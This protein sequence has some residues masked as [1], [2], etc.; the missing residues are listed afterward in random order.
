WREVLYRFLAELTP[1][2]IEAIAAFAYMEMLERG[3]T[4]VGEFHYLHHDVDGRPYADIGEMAARIA[5]AAAR[6]GIGLTLLPSFYANGGFGG[7]APTYAQRRFLNGPDDFLELLARTREIAAGVPDAEV[8]VAPH[9]LR[10]VTP[11][12]LRRVITACDA[13]PIHI[14]AAEQKK[15]VKESV[16]AL[17]RPPVAW[18]VDNCEIGPRWC[19]VHATHMDHAETSR[20]ARSGAVAGLCPL[21][22][23]NLGDGIFPAEPFLAGG[24]R[25]GIGSDS[26]IA[27]DAAA[28][29]RQLEYAQRL[30]HH[31]RNVLAG[32]AGRSTGRRLY[33]GALA[34][35]AQALGRRIGALAPGRRADIVV[36][37]ADHPDLAGRRDDAW[38]DA[39]VFVAG[40]QMVQTVLVGGATLVSEGRHHARATIEGHYRKVVMRL[41]GK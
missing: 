15:E 14:H 13:G 12:A 6:T 35:G 24:G 33:D 18:L 5:A 38:L 37:D 25:F 30:R 34:G 20:V 22:E 11:A 21:T 7:M 8:G 17:G 16:M 40:G 36:L 10:A 29:L 2:D 23:A 28:E 26:N 3:F 41:I 31:A 1:D 27:I 19:L 39:Y 32:E 4:A 9:S